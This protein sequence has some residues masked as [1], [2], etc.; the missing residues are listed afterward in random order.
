MLFRSA[1]PRPPPRVGTPLISPN[2]IGLARL[3]TSRIDS[4]RSGA[5]PRNDLNTMRCAPRPNR[6]RAARSGLLLNS[7]S[8]GKRAGSLRAEARALTSA[9]CAP[10]RHGGAPRGARLRRTPR[11]SAPRHAAP[12][13]ASPRHAGTGT[14]SEWIESDRIAR[15]RQADATPRR[16]ATRW[17]AIAGRMSDMKTRT[18]P[19]SSFC[20]Y[21]N[22]LLANYRKKIEWCAFFYGG[23][24]DCRCNFFIFF[25]LSSQLSQL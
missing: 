22:L 15:D 6:H 18:R 19:C 7:G 13:R 1:R 10:S 11:H 23:S 5:N 12:L 8:G 4:S 21:L 3:G 24:L 14:C 9:P 20:A 17:D 2:H 16:D 25:S